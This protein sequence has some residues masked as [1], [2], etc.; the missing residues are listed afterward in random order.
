[1][2]TNITFVKSSRFE[3]QTANRFI[4]EVLTQRKGGAGNM[5]VIKEVYTDLLEGSEEP[6]NTFHRKNIIQGF[7]TC[8]SV[9]IL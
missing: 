9:K 4:R 3:F 8:L 1:M 6:T 7:V 5:R 2:K